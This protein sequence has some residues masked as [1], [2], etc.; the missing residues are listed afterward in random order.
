MSEKIEHNPIYIPLAKV[1]PTLN[2]EP[3][4]KSKKVITQEAHKELDNASDNDLKSGTNNV[5]QST[6]RIVYA[7]KAGDYAIRGLAALAIFPV[8]FPYLLFKGSEVAVKYVWKN[9]VSDETKQHA[10]TAKTS[11]ANIITRA[12]GLEL[13]SQPQTM[14]NN[15]E[16]V[17]SEGSRSS[18]GSIDKGPSSNSEKSE[19]ISSHGSKSSAS[20]SKE[21]SIGEEPEEVSSH[22]SSSSL[23]DAMEETHQSSEGVNLPEAE[24]DNASAAEIKSE[25]KDV[26]EIVPDNKVDE[27]K[28][29]MDAA[30]LKLPH[31][32][33]EVV[34]T[35]KS[36]FQGL[37]NL[38]NQLNA[39]L[40][41]NK[42]PLETIDIQWKVAPSKNEAFGKEL[43]EYQLIGHIES[44]NKLY[45][46]SKQ[47]EDKIEQKISEKGGDVKNL[48]LEDI[49]EVYND[50]SILSKYT[51]TMKDCAAIKGILDNLLLKIDLGKTFPK[52]SEV[53][54]QGKENTFRNNTIL[55]VQR[56]PRH[57]M[58]LEDLVKTNSLAMGLSKEDEDK[59]GAAKTL[60]KVKESA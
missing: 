4:T 34:A 5:K 49:L 11:F 43:I 60:Q 41:E 22:G 10:A 50:D 2:E 31:I 46:A 54:I 44:F 1:G 53:E 18:L 32:I 21:E 27:T 42:T 30:K 37:E 17:S 47:F 28:L 35:E 8:S 52:A 13:V 26:V 7:Q 36:H 24:A 29:K 14:V 15:L 55:P 19:E 57:V 6:S 20:T 23:E 59:G 58:F 51:E 12:L 9:Q 45:E 39:F 48:N 3:E 40:V 33:G 38:K 56:M 16:N 25:A